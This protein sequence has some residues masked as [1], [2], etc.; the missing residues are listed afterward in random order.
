MRGVR[1]TDDGVLF[2][3][4]TLRGAVPLVALRIVAIDLDELS[5]IDALTKSVRHR[6]EVHFVAIGRKIE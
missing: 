6:N 2:G 1:V 5:V 4:P 3:P